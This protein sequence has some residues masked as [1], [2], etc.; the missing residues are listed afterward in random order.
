MRTKKTTLLFGSQK[1]VVGLAN[2]FQLRL[3]PL[4]VEE[5]LLDLGLEFG[6]D[7][8]LSGDAA[9]I[10][11]GKDANRVTAAGRAFGAT[12]FVA[13]GALEQGASEDLR[14]RREIACDLAAQTQDLLLFHY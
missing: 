10:A 4:I 14:K 11:H 1:S 9:G 5:P 7:G 6:A 3:E 13:D 12:L 8:E 2:G